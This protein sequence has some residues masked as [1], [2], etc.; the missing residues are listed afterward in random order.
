MVT[1][2]LEIVEDPDHFTFDLHSF[3]PW[4]FNAEDAKTPMEWFN[5][6][7]ASAVPQRECAMA[8]VNFG[9]AAANSRSC[10]EHEIPSLGIR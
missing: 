3:K 2:Y 5:G 4:E 8:K 10:H 1:F 6:I 7:C 9:S